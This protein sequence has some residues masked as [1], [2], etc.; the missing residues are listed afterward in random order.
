MFC[1][2]LGESWLTVAFSLTKLFIW[3]MLLSK[4]QKLIWFMNA[5]FWSSLAVVGLVK[6]YSMPPCWCLCCTV[7]SWQLKCSDWNHADCFSFISFCS[8]TLKNMDHGFS[9]FVLFVFVVVLSCELFLFW[10]WGGEVM[11]RC[12]QLMW[13]KSVKRAPALLCLEC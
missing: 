3:M 4:Y 9:L 8:S 5:R 13:Y 6:L 12:S 11:V 7:S 1:S 2:V 10:R